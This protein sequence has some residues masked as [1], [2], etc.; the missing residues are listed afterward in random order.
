MDIRAVQD[1]YTNKVMRE[2]V[3]AYMLTHIDLIAL[4]KVYAREDV[5]HIADAIDLIKQTFDAMDAEFEVTKKS[6]SVNEAR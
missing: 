3:M 2:A 5:S 1:F 4:E 6:S